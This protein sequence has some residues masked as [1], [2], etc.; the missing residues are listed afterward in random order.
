MM[1][2]QW[3]EG[4]EYSNFPSKGM[5][6][7]AR[8]ICASCQSFK[9]T[10]FIRIDD[11]LGSV[12]KIGQYPPWDIKPDKNIKAMLGEHKELLAKGMILESQ[13]YG[14]GSFGY[15]RRIVEDIIGQLLED[16]QS[17]LSDSELMA[18]KSALEKVRLT[19][20]TAEK[21]ELVQD[22]LPPILRPEG[23]NPL[24]L[25]HGVLSEGLHAA[26]DER[27][28]E[29]AGE[30]REILGFLAAQIAI[31]K[32]SSRSFTDKMKI[33]LEKKDKPSKT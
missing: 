32:N 11:D 30:V 3:F 7:P 28:L 24:S 4:K 8:Y 5:T 31:S 19:K 10:F 16:I 22:L 12:T 26:D 25:L 9:R 1:Y 13:G 20:I 29:L 21:I 15:Y 14:I 23:M 27:C 33:L 17:L 6:V 2:N 18:Y